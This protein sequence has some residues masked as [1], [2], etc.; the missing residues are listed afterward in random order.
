MSITA[1]APPWVWPR[2]AYV[3]VPFCAHHCGYCDF[4][5]ATGADERI[6]EYVAGDRAGNGTAARRAA[7]GRDDLH[8][9][10][11]ADLS[12][13]GAA[14]RLLTAINR[15]FPSAKPSQGPAELSRR[16]LHRIDAR[17]SDAGKGRRA[18]RSR[19]QSRQHRRAIVRSAGADRARNAFIRR[20]TCRGRSSASAGGSTTSRSISSSASPGRRSP[21]GMPTLKRALALAPD[22]VSTYGLT[23]EKGT[24]LVEAAAAGPGRGARRRG[25]TGDVPARSRHARRGRL[26]GGTRCPITP[27]RAGSA[28][29]IALIGP[30]GPTS[31]SASGRPA[32]ST[33]RASLNT[34]SL[35]TYLERIAAGR[36]ATIQ[37]ETLEPEE[38]ARETISTQLRRTEGID[39]EQFRDQTGFDLDGSD[40]PAARAVCRRRIVNGR[41][42]TVR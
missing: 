29:T 18:R 21:I 22:H 33:A 4:A 8:R 23:Y 38:R 42:P 26:C 36:P 41:R 2:A 1:P 35:A 31:A 10:R 7:A 6:D 9:R 32:T 16:I 17:E 27:G 3:H 14:R 28:N 20:P 12:E 40:R 15:W 13:R 11:D 34:R 19:R 5:V 30:T 39:R 24:P 25:R 37:S